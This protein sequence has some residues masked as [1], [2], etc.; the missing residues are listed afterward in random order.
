MGMIRKGIKDGLKKISSGPD[1][2]RKKPKNRK[3]P[4]PKRDS[5]R[6]SKNQYK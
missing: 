3:G 5:I 4:R 6:G 1:G 2:D